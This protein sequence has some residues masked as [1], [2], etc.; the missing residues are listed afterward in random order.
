MSTFTDANQVRL[1]LK[2]KLSMYAWYSTSTV[3]AVDDG[4]GVIIGVKHM[5]NG[6]RKLVPPVVDGVSVKAEVE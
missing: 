3:V 6:I 4:F 1:A 2:M 5:D